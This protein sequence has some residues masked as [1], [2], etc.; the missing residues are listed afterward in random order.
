LIVPALLTEIRFEPEL[1]DIAGE[2]DYPYDETADES[3]ADP[4]SFPPEMPEPA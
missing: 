3:D 4:I 1:G 2:L